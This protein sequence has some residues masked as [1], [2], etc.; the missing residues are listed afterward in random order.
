M[1][2]LVFPEVMRDATRFNDPTL[3]CAIAI[4]ALVVA[5]DA[6]DQALHWRALE[7]LPDLVAYIAERSSARWDRA[8]LMETVESLPRSDAV[9]SGNLWHHPLYSA[10]ATAHAH[11]ERA[12]S[13][14]QAWTTALLGW[15]AMLWPVARRPDEDLE[16]R[17]RAGLAIRKLIAAPEWSLLEGPLPAAVP[18][19]WNLQLPSLMVASPQ[20]D[21]RWLRERLRDLL[22]LFKSQAGVLKHPGFNKRPGTSSPTGSSGRAAPGRA[23]EPVRLVGA[24]VTVLARLDDD[25]DSHTPDEAWHFLPDTPGMAMTLA[26]DPTAMEL[27]V[28]RAEAEL[29][30]RPTRPAAFTAGEFAQRI[31]AIESLP[32]APAKTNARAS[33]LVVGLL[34]LAWEALADGAWPL[35]DGRWSLLSTAPPREGLA[36]FKP[37]GA[38]SWEGVL[39]VRNPDLPAP[40]PNTDLTLLYCVAPLIGLPL[41][42]QIARRL[43]QALEALPGAATRRDAQ[44]VTRLHWPHHKL[45]VGRYDR[46]RKVLGK[47]LERHRME[48]GRIPEVIRGQLRQQPGVDDALLAL[49]APDPASELPTASF[50]TCWAV[51]RVIEHYRMAQHAIDQALD[52]DAPDT[53]PAAPPLP[54]QAVDARMGSR[55]VPTPN[56]VAISWQALAPELIGGTPDL[57]CS[58]SDCLAYHNGWVQQTA[59]LWSY[60]YGLRRSTTS[61]HRPI[62]QDIAGGFI[63]ISDKG[64]LQRTLHLT[65]WVRRRW[66]AALAHLELMRTLL[67]TRTADVCCVEAMMARWRAGDLGGAMLQLLEPALGERIRAVPWSPASLEDALASRGVRLPPQLLRHGTRTHGLDLGTPE[68]VLNAMLGHYA[69]GREVWNAHASWTLARM[70]QVQ[71]EWV[72]RRLAHVLGEDRAARPHE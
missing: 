30:T 10:L 63:E 11:P 26:S 41:H 5:M 69:Y 49:L 66:D 38:T 8:A 23:M 59:F 68:S 45:H 3:E 51:D 43:A 62:N 60:A 33:V 47:L 54:W 67:R 27:E 21:P 34:G 9:K 1:K 20:G 39:V 52:P 58:L 53:P 36:L 55:R 17:Y 50:Y 37:L 57:D 2:L 70:G 13:C 7:R 19:E 40:P 4:R 46:V 61:L 64:A 35:H 65:P 15:F 71:S 24:D 14:C 22:I 56:A 28:G 6:P 31:H 32:D 16:R 48:A 44:G 12:T 29:M 18:R 42:P 25:D 72:D